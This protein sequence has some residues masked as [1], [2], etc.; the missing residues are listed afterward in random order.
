MLSLQEIEYAM[1]ELSECVRK[2]FSSNI[3]NMLPYKAALV[4]TAASNE[5]SL[6]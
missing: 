2:L 4:Y 6:F 1:E 5:H 3:E